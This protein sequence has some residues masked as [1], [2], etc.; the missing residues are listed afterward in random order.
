MAKPYTE[1]LW[2]DVLE[3][4]KIS[5]SPAI[6]STWFS[7]THL[8]SV[9]KKEKRPV[10]TV[11]CNSSYVKSTIE[12][13]YFGLLQDTLVE[14]LEKPCDVIFVVKQSPQ[15]N[16]ATNDFSAPLFGQE[17]ATEKDEESFRRARVRPALTFE[18]FAVSSSNQ[19]AWAAAEAVSK[20]PG[21]AYNPLFIWGGVGVGKTHLMN[22]VGHAILESDADAK[23]F[24]CTGEEFTNDIVE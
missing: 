10:V 19:M 13:R 11:G 22:A 23:I 9:E 18:N 24:L 20:N 21:N 7:Q 3:N 5:V 12:S 2:R 1:K 8:V 14:A 16:E 15:K 17:V 4:V 6:F